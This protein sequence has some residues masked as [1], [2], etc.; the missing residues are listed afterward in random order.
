MFPSNIVYPPISNRPVQH[1]ECTPK[2]EKEDFEKTSG[3]PDKKQHSE[4]F[5][6]EQPTQENPGMGRQATPTGNGTSNK[7][8]TD[9]PNEIILKIFDDLSPRD[10]KN[11]ALQNSRLRALSRDWQSRHPVNAW[12]RQMDKFPRQS[13][14][15]R[16]AQ[17]NLVE[18]KI[19]PFLFRDIHQV[20]LPDDAIQIIK[21]MRAISCAH[22]Y[23]AHPP[24]A[25]GFLNIGKTLAS[26][27]T[28]PNKGVVLGGQVKL[29]EISSGSVVI[30]ADEFHY[31]IGCRHEIAYMCDGNGNPVDDSWQSKLEQYVLRSAQMHGLAR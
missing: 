20:N 21:K 30:H 17:Q 1:D 15:L 7:T 2:R 6:L 14:A 3:S 25:L 8:I 23:S 29:N 12:I 11:V 27:Y 18:Q 5:E 4:N 31:L 13:D 16:C 28:L 9:L 24:A 26:K 22:D 10:I 19:A